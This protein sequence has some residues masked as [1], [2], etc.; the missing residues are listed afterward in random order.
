MRGSEEAPSRPLAGRRI[1]SLAL[2]LPGPLAVRRL[3]GLGAAIDKA[4][5]PGGDP[6]E[7]YAPAWYAE[8]HEDIRVERLDLKSADGRAR[9]DEL[10]ARADLLLTSMRPSARRRLGIDFATLHLRFPRLQ[11]VAIVGDARD[12]ERPGHDLTYQAAAG[13]VDPPRPPGTLLA[14]LMAGERVVSAVLAAFLGGEPREVE[15]SI[16]EAADDCAAPRRHGLTREGGMLA[17]GH[18]DYGVYRAQDGWVAVA[19]LE[20]RF[21]KRLHA[22]AREIGSGDDAAGSAGLSALFS[23]RTA[24]W[25]EAWAREQ[26]LPLVAVRRCGE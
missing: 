25:W 11:A 1:V 18:E 7:T 5:P 24:G 17:G 22:V 20:E 23:T 16:Q 4:E 12:P 14:D 19:A 8:L 13:L 6:L 21:R 9:L 26:D 2:N 15:V 3:R 10:L